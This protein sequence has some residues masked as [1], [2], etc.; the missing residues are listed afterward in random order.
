MVHEDR[1]LAAVAGAEPGRRPLTAREQFEAVWPTLQ[2]GEAIYCEWPQ[3]LHVRA[4]FGEWDD[5]F[6]MRR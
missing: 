1:R 4:M 5:R 2:M 3:V 6:L